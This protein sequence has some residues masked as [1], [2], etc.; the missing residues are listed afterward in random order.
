MHVYKEWGKQNDSHSCTYKARQTEFTVYG[1]LPAWKFGLS[2]IFSD[3]I[4]LYGHHRLLWHCSGACGLPVVCGLW[5]P[6]HSTAQLY[7]KPE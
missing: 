7:L 5:F 4:V 3:S 6:V 1:H 2:Q